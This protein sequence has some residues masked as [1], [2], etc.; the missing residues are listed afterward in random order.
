MT[1]WS[2]RVLPRAIDAVCA[3]A[4]PTKHR[5]ALIPRARGDVLDVG[6]GSG[7]N[8]AHA[9]PDRVQ[10]WTGI[11]PS[12]ALLQKARERARGAAFPVELVVGEAE[13]LPFEAGRFD[14][15][16]L[17]YTFCSVASPP[18]TVREIARVLKAGGQLLFAEHGIASSDVSRA[19]QRALD[20]AWRRIAGGCSLQH[21]IVS[22]LVESGAFIVGDVTLREDF[23]HWMPTVRRGSAERRSL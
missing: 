22:A 23:P 5:N 1:F 2:E 9:S 14:T 19:L 17:T 20:P 8:L 4:G 10:R 3:G 21:D 13:A 11:D 16:V 6:I 7:L 18:D 15:V 12:A